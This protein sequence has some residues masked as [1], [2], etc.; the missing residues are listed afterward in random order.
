MSSNVYTE[1]W[2]KPTGKLQEPT[3]GVLRVRE[4][5]SPF[6]YANVEVWNPE[7]VPGLGPHPHGYEMARN[8][9]TITVAEPEPIVAVSVIGSGCIAPGYIICEYLREG[10]TTAEADSTGPWQGFNIQNMRRQRIGDLPRYHPCKLMR[11]RDFEEIAAGYRPQSAL[12]ELLIGENTAYF[13]IEPTTKVVIRGGSGDHDHYSFR[14]IRTYV[15][16]E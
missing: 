6:E 15:L 8:E 10:E 12:N 2:W 9:G 7:G 3:S 16:T 1:D 11:G 14:I 4:Y 13:E 5:R